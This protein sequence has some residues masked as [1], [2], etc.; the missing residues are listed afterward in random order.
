MGKGLNRTSKNL[1]NGRAERLPRS[2]SLVDDLSSARSC[3]VLGGLSE[4]ASLQYSVVAML[5]ISLQH[6]FSRQVQT[7]ESGRDDSLIASE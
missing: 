1:I 3:I 2:Y 5:L 6:L 4:Y 7:R